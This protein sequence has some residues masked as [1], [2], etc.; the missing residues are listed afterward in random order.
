MNLT[1]TIVF[2]KIW[3][4]IHAVDVNNKR[5][6]KYILLKGSSRSSKTRSTIDVYDI[7]AR[8][9]KNK[10][11]TA[12]RDTKVDCKRTVLND[13]LK[14]HKSTNRY[15]NGYRFNK[16]E[17]IFFYNN[18]STIEIHG[19][20][21][22]ETVHGLQQDAAW[23]NEPYKISEDTFDQ[24]DQRTSDFI[25]IDW[26]PKKDFWVDDL[27]NRK[28]TIV[29]HSTFKDNPFCPEEQKK[30]ILSYQPVSH[31]KI[32]LDGKISESDAFTYDLTQN[33]LNFLDIEIKELRRCIYNEKTKS[34]NLN[35]WLV[36]GLGEK[37]ERPN[38]IYFW[39]S[40]SY[41]E[42][43]SLDVAKYYG[44]DWGTVDPFGIVEVKYY[45]GALYVHE[46]NYDSENKIREKL[47]NDDLQRIRNEEEGLVKWLF[48][49]LNIPYDADIITDNN[50]KTKLIALRQS[51]YEYSRETIKWSGSIIDGIDVLNG[52]NVYYTST[53]KNIENEQNEYSR[54]V[55]R[56]GKV[57]EQPEDENNHLMDAIR[58]VALDLQR[59]G[60]IKTI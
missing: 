41:H 3:N 34:A 23:L 14:A 13:M 1:A 10:R 38:R 31:C 42:Y 22:E 46:L 21:D 17:S 11:L 45:D 4:A 59:Q 30:K 35:K 20:D 55:D 33:P 50:R 43:M 60:I 51:G 36:Y 37:G 16:T 25:I 9:N 52:I 2:E 54:K 27:V 56:Y 15:N 6:Y 18:D 58:Y 24:I 29:I 49:K 26:N 44:A 12:W 32:V 57:L 53:S 5:K 7:Y 39:K 8:Q 28:N 47:S 40:I 19:A 48:K